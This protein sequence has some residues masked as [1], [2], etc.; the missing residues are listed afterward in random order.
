MSDLL[1]M[2]GLAE[3]VILDGA[4]GTELQKAGLA[5][6]ESPERW[7]LDHPDRV[8]AVARS[9]VSAGSR[10]ILTNTFGGNRFVL[11]G[12]GLAGQVADV[13]RRG[14][15]IS[16]QA[17]DGRALVFAS[18]GPTGKMLMAGEV[19]EEEIADAFRA[20]AAALHAAGADGLVVETMTDLEEARLAVAAAKETGLPVVGS[21]AY[22]VNERG[23][24][25]MMGVT[26]EQEV[27]AL[28]AAGADVIGANCGNGIVPYIQLCRLLRGLTGRPLWIKPNAGLPELV[29][30]RA[31]YRMS[32]EEFAAQARVLREAGATFVGGCCGT[33]PD[34]IRAL[35]R[36]LR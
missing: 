20:Q 35:C 28:T 19:T 26:P 32:P 4:W 14:V 18:I 17:A 16:R 29:Q 3:P 22:D 8:L 7:N 5:P 11:E 33:G 12:A 6:G 27:E 34:F 1:Q 21:M 25:T 13:N 2:L 15:E 10:I 24:H 31:V 9:Y 23:A 30:G 36:A